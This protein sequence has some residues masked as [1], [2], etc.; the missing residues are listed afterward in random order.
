MTDKTPEEEALAYVSEEKGVADVKAALDGA[1]DILAESISDEADYRIYIRK[2][3]IQKGT[4]ASSA[5]TPE[6][7]SVYEM[8][9]E[10]EE[11]IKKLAGHRILA[12]RRRKGKIDCKDQCS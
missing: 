1:G 6:E 9:Y 7:T 5:R 12:E 10:F 3:T 4:V 11:P 2:L 8:Y